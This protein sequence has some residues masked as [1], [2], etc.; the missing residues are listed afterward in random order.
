MDLIRQKVT[1]FTYE[2][3]GIK[4]IE[5]SELQDA[6]ARYKTE[7]C[8][9]WLRGFCSYGN[10]C[11]FAHGSDEMRPRSKPRNF[12]T[13]FC[14]NILRNGVCPYGRKCQFKHEEDQLNSTSS[15]SEVS[16][17]AYAFKSLLP[18]FD[19]ERRCI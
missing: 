5:C 6:R 3:M 17:D 4:K 19:L 16:I 18:Y 9:N 14:A 1:S 8:K 10:N 7:I 11:L 2:S 15:S 13:K 12:K